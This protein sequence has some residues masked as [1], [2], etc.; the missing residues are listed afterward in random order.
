M[1][2]RPGCLLQSA[3]VGLTGSSWH[4]CVVVHAHNMLKQS[5]SVRLDY[6]SQFGLLR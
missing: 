4:I 2:G 3:G 6:S 1:R 5:K